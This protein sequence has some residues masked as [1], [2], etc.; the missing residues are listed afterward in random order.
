MALKGDFLKI[1]NGFSDTETILTYK[2][3]PSNLPEDNPDYS[4]RGTTVEG[5]S[6]APTVTKETLPNVYVIIT[7]ATIE[8]HM[9]EGQYN[10]NYAYRVYNSKE[11][12]DLDIE[13]HIHTDITTFVWDDTL[14]TTPLVR[15]YEHLS[16]LLNSINL[17]N[18]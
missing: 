16:S 14:D 3:Y 10:I 4:K 12:K 6:P 8:K 2:T 13:S 15:C 17:T 5:T 9:G 7:G 18:A 11:D 1:T